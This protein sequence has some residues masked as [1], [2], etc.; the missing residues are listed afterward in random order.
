[1]RTIEMSQ[2]LGILRWLA[3][4]PCVFALYWVSVRIDDCESL[5]D[6]ISTRCEVVIYWDVKQVRPLEDYIL[7]VELEDGRE[8]V[9][10]VKPYLNHGVFQELQDRSYFSQSGRRI[11]RCNLPLRAGRRAR[12]SARGFAAASR[13]AASLTSIA[14]TY[15]HLAASKRS[16][17]DIGNNRIC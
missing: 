1:M 16:G 3:R 5:R 4:R 6:T 8:G 13:C 10:D 15:V 11:G 12:D 9:F 14:S 7:Y 2:A 17:F